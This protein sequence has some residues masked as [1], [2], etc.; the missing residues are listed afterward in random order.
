MN[1]LRLFLLALWLGA[2]LFFSATV[3][4]AIFMVLRS[5]HLDNTNEIAGTI[6]TRTLAVVNLSGFAIG[7]FLMLTAFLF[8]RA[9]S[10]GAFFTETILLALIVLLTAA[11]QWLISPKMLALRAAMSVPIDQVARTDPRRIAFD[12]LHHYSVALLGLAMLASL[13]ASILIARRRPNV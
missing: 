3:A 9:A 10:G 11:S 13:I 12:S 6:V 7:L 1:K 2:A 5:F 8:K 4:P